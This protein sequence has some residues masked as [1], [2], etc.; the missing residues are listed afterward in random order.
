MAQETTLSNA[1]GEEG[2]ITLGPVPQIS[3]GGNSSATSQHRIG[4]TYSE[5]FEDS[6]IFS[7]VH[8]LLN[9][10]IRAVSKKRLLVL[11]DEWTALAS[12][13]QPY[14]AE[15][16]KRSFLPSSRIT[17]KI[18][19]LEYRSEFFIQRERNNVTG[20][21]LGSDIA[22]TLDLDDYYVY[23]RDPTQV[24][25]VFQ[26]LLF[27]HLDTGLPNNY[28]NE[29]LGAASSA[30][31]RAALFTE[32]ETFIELV[33]AAEGVARDFIHIFT[34]AFFDAKKHRKEKIDVRTVREAARQWYEKDKA[35]NLSDE[36][37]ALLRKIIE[38]VIGSKKA[39]SFLIERPLARHQTIQSLFDYRII[40]LISR[41][42]S[43]KENPG[44]RYDIYTLDYGT[45]V[46]LIHT[47]KQPELDFPD[48][49]APGS[50]HV[51]PF[52]DKRSIRRI[53]LKQELLEARHARALLPG[54]AGEA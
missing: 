32:K 33:R 48:S 50:D 38:E 17:V 40:H 13:V 46:D 28:L 51:V 2:T 39:R 3:I 6:V 23:D 19:S 1:A 9:E 5:I 54:D 25:D 53:I 37:H 27:K 34:T 16:L 18:A 43:D 12:D 42:Y 14:F 35:Q 31:L 36:Q 29:R 49:E 41:G 45:Y 10:A 21:E 26:E 47:K 20:F 52:N 22:T 7:E 24:V 15:F 44:L 8:R 30:S 11:I 4:E